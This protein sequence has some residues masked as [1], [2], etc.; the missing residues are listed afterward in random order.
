[1]SEIPDGVGHTPQL[2]KPDDFSSV[3][4]TWLETI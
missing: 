1:M 2:E 3:G 4:L